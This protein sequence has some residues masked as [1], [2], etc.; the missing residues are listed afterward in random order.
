MP[1]PASLAGEAGEPARADRVDAVARGR[2]STVKGDG[3]KSSFSVVL[4]EPRFSGNIGLVA[5]VMKN[6]GVSDLRIVGGPELKPQAWKRAMHG[7]DVLASARFF[8]SLEDALRDVDLIVGT[9]G[10]P[11]HTDRGHLRISLTPR[12]LASRVR[13][14]RGRVALLFGRENFG[15][16]N[17]ELARCDVLVSIPAHPDYPILNLSHAVAILLYELFLPIA[18]PHR[19]R[20]ASGFEKENA[21]RMLGELLT[22]VNYPPHK[23][24]TTEVMLRRILGRAML[25]EKEFYTLMGV[26]S[27]ALKAARARE[28]SGRSTEGC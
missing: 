16:Y 12:D 15:L 26:V 17:K 9:T 6:F 3:M 27:R 8:G 24:A 22:A 4:V 28:D 20:R 14:I 13:Q 19:P 21:L 2:F 10:V 5:R 25:S 7:R 1:P 11:S 18:R 23:R